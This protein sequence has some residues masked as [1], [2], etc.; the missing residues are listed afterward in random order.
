MP[1]T[2]AGH[3]HL[4]SEP[5]PN[6]SKPPVMEVKPGPEQQRDPANQESSVSCKKSDH[7]DRTVCPERCYPLQKT[8]LVPYQTSSL[9]N[10]GLS[11]GTVT[12]YYLVFIVTFFC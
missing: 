12:F 9:V 2:T 4:H 8:T 10:C 3:F 7:R 5:A 1:V 6:Q 11:K